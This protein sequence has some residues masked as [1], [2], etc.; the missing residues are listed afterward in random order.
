MKDNTNKYLMIGAVALI[1]G[2]AVNKYFKS[3]PKSIDSD[4]FSGLDMDKVLSKGSTGDEVAHL[5][6]M[7]VN[8]YGA[9][10]G[11]TGGEKDGIDGQ[12]GSL[13][14]KALFDA[15]GVNKTSLKQFLTKI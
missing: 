13:T 10:L 6:T 15:K 2:F 12:F 8:Q 4:E 14:E 7:L 9:D 5:Q 1:I 11:F 3:R